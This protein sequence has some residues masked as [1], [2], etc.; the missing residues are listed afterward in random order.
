MDGGL[1]ISTEVCPGRILEGFL[2]EKDGFFAGTMQMFIDIVPALAFPVLCPSHICV[3]TL[4]NF[5]GGEQGPNGVGRAKQTDEGSDF[6]DAVGFHSH[7]G[8]V[9]IAT[10][11]MFLKTTYFC[12]IETQL[13]H[14]GRQI[15]LNVVTSLKPSKGVEV[16]EGVL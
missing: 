8:L 9:H 13:G 11:P 6:R 15:T 4:I 1:R 16:A 3:W 2:V 10:F 7:L 12:C 5:C 14:M